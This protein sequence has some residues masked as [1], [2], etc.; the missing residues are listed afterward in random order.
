MISCRTHRARSRL[1]RICSMRDLDGDVHLRE[2]ARPDGAVGLQAM[3]RLELLDGVRREARRRSRCRAAVP[4]ALP[5]PR[6][7]AAAP[8]PAASF[9][10]GWSFLPAGT[11]AHPPSGGQG[12][13]LG[14]RGASLLVPPVVGTD[15]RDGLLGA[16]PASARRARREGG[17]IADRPQL[18]VPLRIE[19]PS[20]PPCRDTGGRAGEQNASVASRSPCARV[21]ASVPGAFNA[22]ASFVSAALVIILRPESVLRRVPHELEQHVQPFGRP[23]RPITVLPVEDGQGMARQ[24]LRPSRLDASGRFEAG[25]AAPAG[26]R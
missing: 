3:P 18:E 21:A 22:G 6:G 9:A 13:V 23:E 26:L 10:P 17:R 20:D 1:I 19:G 8:G 2:R 12:A 25:R 15:F 5:S 16:C 11:G 14:E 24:D 7:G 4:R